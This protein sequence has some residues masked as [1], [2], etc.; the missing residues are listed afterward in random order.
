MLSVTFVR[1]WV[2]HFKNKLKTF[3]CTLLPKSYIRQAKIQFIAKITNFQTIQIFFYPSGE[4]VANV[5]RIIQGHSHGELT[6]RGISMAEHLGRH[7]SEEK[8]TRVFSSDLKRCH[9][10]TRHILKHSS[11]GDV[12]EDLIVLDQVLR[13]VVCDFKKL[14]HVICTYTFI[15]KALQKAYT[16]R[17]SGLK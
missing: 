15:W 11:D 16:L 5:G 9:D 6:E 7:L 17:N 10:T 14:Y 8:F 1:Q 13:E 2:H 4:T 3:F 12:P